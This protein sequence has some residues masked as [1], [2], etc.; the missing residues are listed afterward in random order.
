MHPVHGQARS[1][2][3]YV[4]AEVNPDGSVS[5]PQAV[6]MHVEFPVEQLR[7]G[8]S[9]QDAQMWKM[10]DSKRFPLVS[11]DL[12][13]LQPTATPNKYTATGAVTLAGRSRT[14]TGELTFAAGSDSIAVDGNLDVDIRDFG[15]K[16]PNLLII[17]VEPVVKVSLH[18]VAKSGA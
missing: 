8:N 6:K 7:S 3:G 11:A 12:K 9:L 17:K 2:A 1:L 16:P 10:I 15:L 13:D 14:Y 5:A 18:L 4:E